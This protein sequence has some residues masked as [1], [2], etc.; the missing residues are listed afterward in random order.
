LPTCA[1][2]AKEQVCLQVREEL[3]RLA[4]ELAAQRRAGRT[5]E[6]HAL[7][8]ENSGAAHEQHVVVTPLG[9]RLRVSLPALARAPG[10]VEVARDWLRAQAEGE[11]YRQLFPRADLLLAGL[12]PPS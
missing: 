2:A 7:R 6:F 1:R 9:P 11:G 5:V 10:V 4:A 12:L 3:L 8:L